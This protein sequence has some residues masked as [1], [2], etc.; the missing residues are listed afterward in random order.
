MTANT[1]N[2]FSR[3]WQAII[4][5]ALGQ[6][7]LVFFSNLGAQKAY[8]WRLGK[9]EIEIASIKKEIKEDI[10]PNLNILSWMHG[11]GMRGKEP[12]IAKH[13]HKN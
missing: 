4:L 12:D 5:L 9:L 11:L 13:E 8:D 1:K 10:K 3:N 2:F 6:F 7:L